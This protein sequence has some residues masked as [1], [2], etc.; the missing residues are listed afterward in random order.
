MLSYC[1]L[2]LSVFCDVNNQRQ[3]M[4][5]PH[6]EHSVVWRSVKCIARIY[7]TYLIYKYE[8]KIIF[9]SMPKNLDGTQQ[10][11]HSI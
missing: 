9:I 5:E 6:V 2:K 4:S 1:Q 3:A 11:M 10:E 8:E 7:L